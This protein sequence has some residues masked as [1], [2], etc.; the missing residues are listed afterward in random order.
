MK[1]GAASGRVAG[2]VATEGHFRQTAEKLVET[3][4]QT[5]QNGSAGAKKSELGKCLFRL[6]IVFD[7]VLGQNV[8]LSEEA[9]KSAKSDFARGGRRWDAAAAPSAG[10]ALR[11]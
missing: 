6:I 7:V 5:N 10:G 8:A 11:P 4:K 3:S 9:E 2:N 1:A